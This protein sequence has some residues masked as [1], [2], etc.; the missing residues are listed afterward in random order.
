MANMRLN[1]ARLFKSQ[2]LLLLL[3]LRQGRET[4]LNKYMFIGLTLT[5]LQNERS[6][7]YI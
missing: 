7:K 5:A 6:A 3:S 4:I 1:E 2:R